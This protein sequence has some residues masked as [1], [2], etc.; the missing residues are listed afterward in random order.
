MRARVTPA[1]VPGVTEEE[2]VA[3]TLYVVS[4]PIGNLGDVTARAAE[5]LRTAD[6]VLCEDTRHSR[7]LLDHANSRAPAVSLHEHNEARRS[8]EVV[9][10]LEA[11]ATVALGGC[12]AS[13]TVVMHQPDASGDCRVYL[14]H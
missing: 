3:G 2:K 6:A 4:T 5:V 8:A 12:S 7:R 1:Y 10:R 11:G 9:A 13:T 14:L